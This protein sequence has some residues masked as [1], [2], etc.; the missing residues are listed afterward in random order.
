MEFDFTGPRDPKERHKHYL[1]RHVVALHCIDQRLPEGRDKRKPAVVPHVLSGFL[2]SV[3]GEWFWVTAGHILHTLDQALANKKQNL[4]AWR[5]VDCAAGKSSDDSGIPFDYSGAFKGYLD[6][7][8]I[9]PDYRMDVGYIWVRGNCRQL[10]EAVG[11][12]PLSEK[13]WGDLRHPF[14]VFEMVGFPTEKIDNNIR[15][16]GKEI[17]TKVIAHAMGV[18][19]VLLPEKSETHLVARIGDEYAD[20]T[21][22]SPPLRDM[23]GMSGA[24]IFGAYGEGD[25]VHYR[26]LAV[27][28][29]WDDV[30]REI[31]GFPV[32]HLGAALDAVMTTPLPSAAD[33]AGPQTGTPAPETAPAPRTTCE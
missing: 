2:L 16:H 33:T 10:L 1:E 20:P 18:P 11:V 32:S 21:L 15:F 12:T 17:G 23:D 31:T 9:N 29:S 13:A 7:E 4:G 6:T 3:R 26:L 24:P 14:T 8:D 22:G 28:G 30:T 25:R 27:Q 19:V 5:F